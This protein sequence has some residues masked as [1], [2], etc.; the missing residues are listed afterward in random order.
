MGDSRLILVSSNRSYTYTEVNIYFFSSGAQLCEKLFSACLGLFALPLQF[1]LLHF[2]KSFIPE[3]KAG[4][5]AVR[6]G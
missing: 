4:R 2:L 1:F 3:E 6:V 5:Q